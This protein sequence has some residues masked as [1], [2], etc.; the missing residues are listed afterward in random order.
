MIEGLVLQMSDMATLAQGVNYLWILVVTFLI[1]FMHAGFAMLEAGQVRSKNVANQLT[2]NMLT[3]ATFFERT[4]PASSIAKPA[5]MKKM[6]NVTVRIHVSLMA[7]IISSVLACSTSPSIIPV[8]PCYSRPRLEVRPR[9]RIFQPCLSSS[10]RESVME[11][12]I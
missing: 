8:P 4:C 9:F 11:H 5:C 3:W 12:T 1:F 10:S 7:A 6:R 2:K